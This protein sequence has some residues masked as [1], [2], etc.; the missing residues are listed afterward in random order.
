MES[1]INILLVDENPKNRKGLK[2]IL[3]GGGNNVLT[4]DSLVEAYSIIQQ[5]EI[6][7]LLV[8]IDN[9]NV[10][11]TNFWEKFN[12]LANFQTTYKIVI[13]ADSSS[14]VKMVKGLRQGAVD[15]ITIPFNPN[16]IKAK[17]EVY[18]SLF[19]K[20]QR[21]SQLLQNIFP[22]TV[23]KDLNAIHK[24]TPNRVE[25]GVV[26]F[27]DFVDFSV[28]SK[29]LKPIR[30]LKK[31][32]YYFTQ[33]DEIIARYKLEKIKTIGDAYMAIGGVTENI[34]EPAIRACLAA[35]E[36]RNFMKNEQEVARALHKDFWEI[37]IGIHMGPLV[38]GIIGTS[39]MSFDVWGDT[40]NIA[41]RAESGTQPG[42]ITITKNVA[43]HVAEFMHL[44]NRGNITIHKRGG[45]I[46]MFFLNELKLEHCLYGEGKSASSFLR[47]KCGLSPID[48]RQM[49]KDILNQLKILLPN[50]VVYHD[51]THTLNV[52]KAVIR[53][54]Q[55]E[56]LTELDKTLLLTAALFHDAGFIVQPTENEFFAVKMAQNNLPKYGYTADQIQIISEMIEATAATRKPKT[57]LEKILCDADHDY[58]GRAD[59]HNVAAKL[60]KEF[61]NYEITYTEK[62]W[63]E[64]QIE[65]LANVHRYHTETAKN[66]RVQGKKA[67]IVELTN[68]LKTVN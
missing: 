52:E 58:L 63:I 18:K 27:T 38:A 1:F 68:Q 29:E 61:E 64:F 6:G 28:K 47:E 60:R 11:E 56:G 36:I 45:S 40:V 49:R 12:A 16:L 41:S 54:A 25:N 17:I 24:F 66:I 51:V 13:T 4:A 5:K 37:R 33:F 43:L 62:E 23:L 22:L 2:E 19:Q 67:R 21:I 10:K 8:N 50:Q 15:Y 34:Q 59:Y 48:F 30:L 44:E 46:E 26:L 35:I 57:I 39:K 14:G 9:Q 65:Y 20:D 7:I 53:F 55:L 3:T 32:A 31:L 42:T